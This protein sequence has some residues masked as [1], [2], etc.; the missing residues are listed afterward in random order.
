MSVVSSI[1]HKYGEP[2]QG[3][4][5]E[6]WAI[7]HL[8]PQARRCCIRIPLYV[9]N[10]DVKSLALPAAQ[11]VFVGAITLAINAVKGFTQ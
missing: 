2:T 7:T 4:F 10:V 1:S 8:Y 5:F 9:V 3:V 11:D 6:G